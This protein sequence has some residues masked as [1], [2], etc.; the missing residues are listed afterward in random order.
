MFA[1]IVYFLWC[2]GESPFTVTANQCVIERSE[3]TLLSA[4]I[5]KHSPSGT[6]AIDVKISHA[7]LT[8]KAF[9]QDNNGSI[10]YVSGG[11][12]K[13]IFCLLN[14]HR[15]EASS[16]AVFHKPWNTFSGLIC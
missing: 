7:Q 13:I 1:I 16:H 10:K 6:V 3:L 15:L 9:P 2:F 5:S 14:R 4:E 11:A 8:A 12:H